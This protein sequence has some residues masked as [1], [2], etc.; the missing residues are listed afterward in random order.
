MI[1]ARQY[2]RSTFLC[3]DCPLEGPSLTKCN[4]P[5]MAHVEAHTYETGHTVTETRTEVLTWKSH[6]PKKH[7]D[8]KTKERK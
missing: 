8:N 5:S 4:L 1:G 7:P 6:R 3:E 2:R